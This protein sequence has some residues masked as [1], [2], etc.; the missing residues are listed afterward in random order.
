MKYWFFILILSCHI[1]SIEGQGIS[2]HAKALVIGVSQ[3]QDSEIQ[4]LQLPHRDAELFASFLK[5]NHINL[6]DDENLRLITNAEATSARIASSLDWLF[7][8]MSPSDTVILFFEGYGMDQYQ[9]LIP[10]SKLYF[11]DTPLNLNNAGS[12]DLFL[13]FKAFVDKRKTV[14]KV[15]GNL[16]P[17]VLTPELRND[18]VKVHDVKKPKPLFDH[19]VFLNSIGQETYTKSLE[20]MNAAKVSLNHLLID[21]M[22]GLADK[23]NDRAVT[24]KELGQYLHQQKITSVIWPGLLFAAGNSNHESLAYV[25]PGILKSLNLMTNPTFSAIVDLETNSREDLQL[26][27]LS[28][29]N[30]QLYEDFIVALKLGHLI[31]P[32]GRNALVFSDSL[33]QLKELFP[34]YGEIKRK[35]AAA[36]QDETQQALNAYLNSDSREMIRRRN[37]SRQYQLYPE[38]LKLTCQLLGEHHYLYPILTAKRLYFEGLNKRI[39]GQLSRDKALIQEALMLQK[40]ALVF[41]KEAAFIYN[42]I[43]V[44]YSLLDLKTEAD[45]NFQLAIEYAPNWSIPFSNLAQ[46]YVNEDIPKALRIARHAIRLSPRNS[47]AYSVEGTIYFQS[48]EYLKAEES[49]GKALKL[50]PVY[51]D[52]YYNMACLKSLQ[53]DYRAAKGHFEAAI[54]NG[55]TDIAHAIQDPDLEAFRNQNE[56]NDLLK[57]YFP[58]R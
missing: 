20:E 25:D 51:A 41:E 29:K 16:Y 26:S 32:P 54:Q 45:K 3:Y 35:L 31:N 9:N 12:F 42:E 15:F 56:W 28:E 50:D 36:L 22:L 43:A 33:L 38:Y 1:N 17:M 34:L 58:N 2:G 47:F 48:K 49:F 46:I 4:D 24:L 55:F 14:Y 7:E 27:K 37:G 53:G 6:L 10:S 52:V 23:N 11:Y 19:M 5:S 18:S 39:E 21:G 8:Y 44:N 30:R 13:Q 40:Q 57:K